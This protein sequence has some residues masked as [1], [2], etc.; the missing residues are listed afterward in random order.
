M[1]RI[2]L[3]GW[4]GHRGMEGLQAY[5]ARFPIVE[6]DSSFYAVQPVRN[7]EK[8]VRSTPDDFGFVIKAYQGMTGHQRGDVP[9]ASKREM[10]AAFLNSI[11]PVREAGKCKMVLFQYPPWFDCTRPHVDVLRYTK[12][13]M[14]DLP[15]ALEF[16]H[17]SWFQ[18][19]MQERTLAFMEQEGWIHSIVDEPQVN[20]GSVPIV[21]HPTD[22]KL[23][24]IRF[25]GRNR[26]AW[27]EPSGENWREKR[28]LYRY[29]EEE[30]ARWAER[31]RELQT[32]TAEICVIFNNNSGGDAAAN[33]L[34]L[35]ELLGVEYK[36]EP[37]GQIS[38]FDL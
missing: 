15:L 37:P 20:P 33:A 6:V 31:I 18:P 10:F 12:E 26:E 34:Q 21:L 29:S 2:G 28:Y 36:G 35:A 38:F 7:Y 13:K 25:H 9:F 32:G 19:E 1:I 5:S 16:R 24:L 4:N 27:L 14:G 22:A 8:W 11:A 17:Q 23:T 30:L 3:T